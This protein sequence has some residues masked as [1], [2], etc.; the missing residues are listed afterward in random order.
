VE[1]FC[2]VLKLRLDCV[3][4]AVKMFGFL[5]Y[6]Q[7]F[8]LFHFGL[9]LLFYLSFIDINIYSVLSFAVSCFFICMFFEFVCC[10][11]GCLLWFGLF[12]LLALCL[13]SW[14]R[15]N[16]PTTTCLLLPDLTKLT[17]TCL[18]VIH[19]VFGIAAQCSEVVVFSVYSCY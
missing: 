4:M 6:F 5:Y 11:C 1:W 15:N 17:S 9:P 3:L 14:L 12:L 10:A 18:T 2:S 16:L 13:F 19:Q 7:I 8:S